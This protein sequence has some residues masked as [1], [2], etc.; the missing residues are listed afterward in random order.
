VRRCNAWFERVIL[1]I[2]T[3]IWRNRDVD[4]LG[5]AQTRMLID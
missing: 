2:G 5:S 4:L 1:S 3:K